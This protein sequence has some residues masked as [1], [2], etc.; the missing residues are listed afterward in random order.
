VR[1]LAEPV[2]MWTAVARRAPE[3]GMEWLRA[4]TEELWSDAAAIHVHF[5]QAAARIGRGTLEPFAGGHEAWTLADG[6]RT[7][8]LRAPR[9][10]I[11]RELDALY[12]AGAAD[13]RRAILRALPYLPVGEH[14]VHLVQDALAS[15][16]QRLVAAALG[17]YASA[18]LHERTR[19][20]VQSLS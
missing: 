18:Y 2:G 11:L 20:V 13:E 19:G 4:A 3:D 9:E 8:L 14:A 7:L 1:P 16:D 10:R 5:P 6:A 15:D 12:R 17:P